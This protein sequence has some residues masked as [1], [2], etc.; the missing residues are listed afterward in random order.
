MTATIEKETAVAAK[1]TKKDRIFEVTVETAKT[2]YRPRTGEKKFSDGL[3]M[4]K[5][6]ANFHYRGARKTNSPEDAAVIAFLN[7][8]FKLSPA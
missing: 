8:N 3:D 5:W 4:G 2:G 1:L 6:L 7:D